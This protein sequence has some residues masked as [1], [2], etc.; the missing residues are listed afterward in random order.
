MSLTTCC[1][2][3]MMSSMFGG[4]ATSTAVI[5]LA[6][7]Q[8]CNGR[9]RRSSW[10]V[11]NAQENVRTGGTRAARSQTMLG[12]DSAGIPYD[13]GGC[14]NWAIKEELITTQCSFS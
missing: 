13:Q 12:Q 4:L 1:W 14:I 10:R 7:Q 5:L 9:E 2:A 3:A 6:T 11:Q 8:E